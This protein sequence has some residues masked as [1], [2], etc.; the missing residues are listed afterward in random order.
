VS[1][2]LTSQNRRRACEKTVA[3]SASSGTGRFG[4]TCFLD[5]TKGRWV[6]RGAPL[7]PGQFAAERFFAEQI[8]RQ[9]DVPS[10][11][12][13]LEDASA[14][15]FGWPYAIMPRL[16]GEQLADRA[17]LLAR[18][19]ADQV[20]IARALGEGLARLQAATWHRAGRYDPGRG[21]VVEEDRV[22]AARRDLERACRQAPEVTT[23]EAAAWMEAVIR[24]TAGAGADPRPPCLVDG[25]YK[26][27]NVVVERPA[28]VWRLA[29]V[30]DLGLCWFGDGEAALCRQTAMYLERDPA[31]PRTSCR[32]TGPP[33][34]R[35]RASRSASGGRCC[36]SASSSGSGPSAIARYGGSRA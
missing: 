12:P 23:A 16:P 25:D 2:D 20:G 33:G 13:Y 24:D 10:P 32:R 18:R 34:L 3:P 9:T 27:D 36:W 31:W 6:L 19:H 15:T 11:W 17:W 7:W 29:G 22:A 26:E 30:F 4:Q 21:E 1:G 35:A 8:H 28:G 14:D 5:S